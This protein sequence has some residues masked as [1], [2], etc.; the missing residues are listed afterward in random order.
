MGDDV[1]GAF[2][3][4]DAA[5]CNVLILD[6]D[7]TCV[8]EYAE[9][10]ESLGYT[11]VT[12]LD[13]GTALRLLADDK[14]IGIVMTDLQMPSMDGLTFLDELSSRFAPIRPLVAIVVT[15]FGSLENA[16]QAM[17]FNAVDFLQKPVSRDN[18]ALALRRASTRWAQ[19]VGQWRLRALMDR[20]RQEPA[21]PPAAAAPKASGDTAPGAPP[22]A[23][24]LQ[25]FVRSIIRS[26]QQ[27]SEFLDPEL[28]ADPSWDILLDLTSAR[29]EGKPVPVSS[30]C[31]ASNVPFTTAFRYVKLL[32]DAGLVRRWND[33]ADKRRV[34]LELEDSTFEAMSAYLSAI[35]RR[36]GGLAI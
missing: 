7:A 13:A 11:T 2:S 18:L 30:A 9:T 5:H 14:R 32:V 27:R 23:K 12:A 26:R 20:G 33:P 22:D 34:L 31:A 15:G 36:K 24:E 25:A 35:M 4:M 8:E 17:R 16:V 3:D 6:D 28:F 29:F 21:I 19:L 1:D 10:V